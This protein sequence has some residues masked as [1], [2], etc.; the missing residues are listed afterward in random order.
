[1]RATSPAKLA[2]GTSDARKS[3]FESVSQTKPQA[4][5]F[6]AGGSSARS[7]ASSFSGRRLVSVSVPGVMMREIFLTIVAAL[8]GSPCCSTITTLSPILTRRAM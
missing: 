7:T 1:M 4:P 5:S 3:P 2:A 6:L 8:P